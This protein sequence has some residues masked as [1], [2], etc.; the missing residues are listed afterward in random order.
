MEEIFRQAGAPEGLYTNL[1]ISGE[2]ASRL[3]ADPRVKGATLTGSEK[4]GSSFAGMAGQYVKKSLLEL[5]G[6]DPFIVLE[7]ADLDIAVQNAAM[8]RLVNAGQVC[9]SPK[10]II[11]PESVADEFIERA[12]AIYQSIKVGDP[13]DA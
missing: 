2:K 7:D 3:V 10:R 4:A 1:F 12:K 13:M 6:S 5:G 9:I 8:G 11:V